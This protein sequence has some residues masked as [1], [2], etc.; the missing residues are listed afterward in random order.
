MYIGQHNVL[1]Y[2]H[3]YTAHT[4]FK[5]LEYLCLRM[6]APLQAPVTALRP[7][8]AYIVETLDATTSMKYSIVY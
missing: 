1:A 2:V 7:H 4:H 3:M 5:L 8:R 6:L